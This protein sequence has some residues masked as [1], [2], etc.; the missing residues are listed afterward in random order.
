MVSHFPSP[1]AG[2]SI[3]NEIVHSAASTPKTGQTKK[4]SKVLVELFETSPEIRPDDDFEPGDTLDD[5]TDEV[6]TDYDPEIEMV[7][8]RNLGS[9]G[10]KLSNDETFSLFL[11]HSSGLSR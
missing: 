6:D 3:V 9:S 8:K 11:K 4:T 7:V 10:Y 2:S 5:I 1:G